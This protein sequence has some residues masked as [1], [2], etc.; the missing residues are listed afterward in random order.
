MEAHMLNRKQL[1]KLAAVS[2][3]AAPL[4]AFAD[5]TYSLTLLPEN[6]H[7]YD[8]GTNGLVVGSL[9]S[10]DAFVPSTWASGTLTT[11]GTLGG[12]RG[13]FNGISANG[14]MTGV[15]DMHGDPSG[16]A[17]VFEGGAFR[18]IGSGLGPEVIGGAVNSS[19]QVAGW[20]WAGVRPVGAFL[21]SGGAAT[22]IADG[23]YKFAIAT[24]INEAGVVVGRGDRWDTDAH[25]AFMYAG[26]VTTD[27]GALDPTTDY[28][29]AFGINNYGDIVGAS[30]DAASVYHAFIYSHGS[31]RDLGSFDGLAIAYDINNLDQVVG[32][33]ANAGFLYSGGTM[34]DLNALL[35]GA[36]SWKV[37]RADAINDA[38]QIIGTACISEFVCRDV[39]LDPVSAVPE[40]ST[41]AMLVAALGGLALRRTMR[42][43]AAPRRSPDRRS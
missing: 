40:P 30:L 16:H 33:G 36:G 4:S 14:I 5:P 2:L 15:S 7:A 19:G 3:L 32:Y 23:T 35:V 13:Q 12:P 9:G 43:S 41:W 27:L 26:G 1:L 38:G 17:F 21:Y 18:E 10:S 42:R 28:S 8:I 6:F 37:T 11:Y 24:G 31:M 34:L 39:V 20:M 22:Q 29:E 25:H